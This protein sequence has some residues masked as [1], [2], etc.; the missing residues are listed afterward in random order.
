MKMILAIMPTSLSEQ[1]SKILIDLEFRVT[2]FASTAGILSGGT[3]TLMVGVEDDKVESGLALIRNQIPAGEA[4]DSA[5]ARVTLYVLNVKD[6]DR[7]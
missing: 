1:T 6:F 2:K 7:L 5:H 4:T 3:T